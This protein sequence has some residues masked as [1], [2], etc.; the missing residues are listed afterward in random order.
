MVNIFYLSRAKLRFFWNVYN[1]IDKLMV[2]IESFCY[3]CREI[4]PSV[5]HRG[6]F[7]A[8]LLAMTGGCQRQQGFVTS[9]LAYW[10]KVNTINPSCRR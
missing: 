3:F 9:K 6:G 10:I 7:G 8:A 5:G 4:E 2:K 1:V